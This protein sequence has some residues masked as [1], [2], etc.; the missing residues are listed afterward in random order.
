[1]P[2][3]YEPAASRAWAASEPPR[4]VV[5]RPPLVRSRTAGWTPGVCDAVA[6]HLGV[7]RR[8]VRAA[9]VVLALSGGAGV[10]A[11]LILWALT[12]ESEDVAPAG[13]ARGWSERRR[14]ARARVSTVSA[15]IG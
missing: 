3:P 12:S 1:M 15:T 8:L 2:T 5:T 10:A 6:R 4:P 7:S 14:S 13:S 9:F 11:Y